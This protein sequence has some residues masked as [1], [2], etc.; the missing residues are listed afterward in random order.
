MRAQRRILHTE[1]P[2]RRSSFGP[3]LVA[4]LLLHA[5]ALFVVPRSW[6]L[7]SVDAPLAQ[8]EIE[9]VPPEEAAPPDEDPSAVPPIEART[10][11][12]DKVVETEKS[13]LRDTTAPN[14]F[15]GQDTQKVEKETRAD[16]VDSFHPKEAEGQTTLDHLAIGDLLVQPS[17]AIEGSLASTDDWLDGVSKGESTQLNTREFRFVSFYRRVKERLRDTW[18][19][20]VEKRYY[21]LAVQGLL[22][23][24]NEFVTRVVATLDRDGRL[25]SIRRE[26]SSGVDAFDLTAEEAFQVA[27]QFANPPQAL[28]DAKG[29]MKLRWEFV[30]SHMGPPRTADGT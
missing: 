25:L 15:F 28:L 27:G 17:D 5:L 24:R 26:S 22:P 16:R 29:R 12:R 8:R 20:V 7:P 4:S 14:A 1:T 10:P 23:R 19:P 30:V 9:V 18:K 11:D 2:T 6:F 21:N 3:T 13:P